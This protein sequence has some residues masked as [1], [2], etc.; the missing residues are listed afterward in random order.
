MR[1]VSWNRCDGFERKFGHLERLKPDIAVISECRPDC[2]RSAGL[3]SQ[4]FWIGDPGKKGLAVICYNGW[5][6]AEHSPVVTQKWFAPLKLRNGEKSIRLVA[7][8][9]ND[10]ADYVMPTI[11]AWESLR[12]FIESGPTIMTGDFNQ[13][14]VFDKGKGPGRR[15]TDVLRLFEQAQLASAWHGF[16]GEEHGQESQATLHWRWQEASRFHIDYV[17]Y[18]PKSL[19]VRSAVLGTYAQYVAEKISDHVPLIVDLA[20]LP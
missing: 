13:S 15:F 1:I 14:V 16:T 8:W 17:F 7:V 18:P 9:L 11:A 2:L 5:Q 12:P 20:L 6:I 4:S 19:S 3:S 10:G